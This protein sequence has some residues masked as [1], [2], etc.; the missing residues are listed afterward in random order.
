MWGSSGSG[1]GQFNHP[2]GV[3]I[4]T[5]NNVYVA[6]TDNHRIQKFTSDGTFLTEWGSDGA[7]YGGLGEG[8]FWGPSGVA[9]DSFGNVYVADTG[10]HRIQKFGR[11][12][13][14]SDIPSEFWAEDYISAIACGGI[15][16]GYGD[17]TYQPTNIVNRAEMA[18]YIVR[19]ESFP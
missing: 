11:Y 4:D 10:N 17:G 3:A 5:S 6:D 12:Y 15:S 7:L 13:T 14:F 2:Y 16:T 19:A 18:V 9:V 1:D 8:L